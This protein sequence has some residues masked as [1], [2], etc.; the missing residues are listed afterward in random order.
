MYSVQ[1]LCV[2]CATWIYLITDG[3]EFEEF[4]DRVLLKLD[5]HE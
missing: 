3:E 5:H 2:S 1:S 4:K